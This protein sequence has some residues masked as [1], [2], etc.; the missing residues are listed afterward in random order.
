MF[1]LIKKALL[2]GVGL[3][4]M[5]KDKA[6]E[7]GRELVERGEISEKEGKEFVDE[8]LKKSE[9]AS[10]D[11]EKKVEKTVQKALAKLNVA[12]KDDIA[13]LSSKIELLGKGETERSE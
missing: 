6:E 12:T 5:T 2:T 7:L 11:F 4:V 8:L 13:E 10:K 3:A 9:Q 1:A